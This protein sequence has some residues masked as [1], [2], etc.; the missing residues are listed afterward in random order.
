MTYE[1]T[2][3]VPKDLL[4]LMSAS[5][6]TETRA[7]GVYKFEMQQAIPAYLLAVAVGRM[8][9]RSM[10][11]VSGVYAEPEWIDRAAWE[12]AQTEEMI[13]RGAVLR[14][15]PL[16]P[17]RHRRA[18]AELSLRRHGKP[19]LDLRHPDDPGRGPVAGGADRP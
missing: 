6:P 1:A 4:A 11:D 16:G 2:L 10:G 15:V 14:P 12:F 7:D 18:A 8:E 17:L 3:R 5:N 9:F 19:T 13:R